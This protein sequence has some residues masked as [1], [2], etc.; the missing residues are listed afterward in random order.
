MSYLTASCGHSG[1][2]Q[3]VFVILDIPRAVIRID[4]QIGGV[5]QYKKLDNLLESDRYCG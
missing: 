3:R 2:F 4:C 5:S 1:L